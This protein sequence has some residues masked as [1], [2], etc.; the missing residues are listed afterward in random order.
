M[1]SNNNPAIIDKK[2]LIEL[3]TRYGGELVDGRLDKIGD[4][5]GFHHQLLTQVASYAGVRSQR[6]HLSNK[7][8]S[9]GKIGGAYAKRNN[10]D[11]CYH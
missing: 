9:R 5:L 4:G 11:L 2:A 8:P 10:C 7:I 6:V 3:Y 1:L